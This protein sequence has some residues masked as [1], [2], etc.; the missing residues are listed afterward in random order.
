VCLLE[1]ARKMM[2]RIDQKCDPAWFSRPE[3]GQKAIGPPWERRTKA[4]VESGHD[5][6]RQPCRLME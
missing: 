6:V 2:I 1:Q 5:L 4:S 3:T